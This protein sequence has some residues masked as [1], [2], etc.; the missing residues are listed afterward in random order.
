MRRVHSVR[1]DNGSRIIFVLMLRHKCLA[2][3]V[4]FDHKRIILITTLF[5]LALYISIKDNN[6]ASMRTWNCVEKSKKNKANQTNPRSRSR[7]GK[8]NFMLIKSVIKH[9]KSQASV[10]IIIVYQ[11]Q[12]N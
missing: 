1:S 9:N 4:P 8:N 6:I 12:F 7:L 11:S 10:E 3:C 2:E 5:S